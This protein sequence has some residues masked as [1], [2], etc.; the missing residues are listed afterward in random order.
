VKCPTDALGP[1]TQL[2][3]LDIDAL[4]LPCPRDGPNYRPRLL[5]EAGKAQ[6]PYLMD[7]NT[8]AAM[9]ESADIVAYLAKEYGDGVV[10]AALTG[11]LSPLLLGL[12]L[13]PRA[14]KGARY[15]P[16]KAT[17]DMEP[18]TL[19][20]YEASPFTVIVRETLTELEL[21]HIWRTV[22]RGSH[23]RQLLLDEE[24]HFQA[25]FLSDPN[26]VTQSG[27]YETFES[28]HIIE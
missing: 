16:S 22:A 17:A 24:G 10:P 11:P 6:F 15:R 18:L 27:P 26:Q 25:P 20:G 7:P 28:G 13:L 21:P 2:C 3:Y 12:A 23:K 4:V 5:A 19:W 9:Y 1:C 14:G 8:G